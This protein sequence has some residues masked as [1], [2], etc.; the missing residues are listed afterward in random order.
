MRLIQRQFHFEEKMDLDKIF[1]QMSLKPA[2]DFDTAP[3]KI[4]YVNEKDIHQKTLDKSDISIHLP[5]LKF[6]AY[7]FD[8]IV[9][10]G[11]RNANSTLA[12]LSGNPKSLISVDINMTPM[13]DQLKDLSNWKFIKCSSID[14]NLDIGFPQLLIIDSNHTYDHC[15]TELNVHAKK[16]SNCIGLHDTISCPGITKAVNEFLNNNKEWFRT[17]SLS[18]CHGFDIIQRF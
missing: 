13:Y 12:L 4:E 3:L 7:Q 14:P 2:W 1:Q 10:F 6:L 18:A 9:E 5:L 15:L 16:V 8:Y 11:V 17:Y